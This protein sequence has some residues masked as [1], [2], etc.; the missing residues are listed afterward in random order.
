MTRSTALFSRWY[1]KFLGGQP[2]IHSVVGIGPLFRGSTFNGIITVL[3]G[4]NFY[5]TL[6]TLVN[7]FCEAC[8]QVV[9]GSDFLTELHSNGGVIPIPPRRSKTDTTP[10]PPPLPLTRYLMVMTSHD[11]LVTP[12]TSGYLDNDQVQHVV[13]E[14]V[15][16]ESARWV[17]R[18]WTLM[19][20]PITFAI[21]DSFLTPSHAHPQ[22]N[23]FTT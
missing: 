21:V 2:K 3:K 11:E 8:T 20:S 10:P 5:N 13:M 7:P 6:A 22:I 12:Y 15:C 23:C 9:E 16:P 4:L 19:F 1:L 17:G 18:H 14:D